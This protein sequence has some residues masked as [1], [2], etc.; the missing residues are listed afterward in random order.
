MTCVLFL[1]FIVLVPVP[2][3]VWVCLDIL[4]VNTMYFNQSNSFHYSSSPFSL[5]LC[6]P[7][8]FSVFRYVLLLHKCNVFQYYLLPI[9]LFFFSSSLSLL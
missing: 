3:S 9:I 2:C 4:P 1:S 7:T 8:V 6:C 5:S